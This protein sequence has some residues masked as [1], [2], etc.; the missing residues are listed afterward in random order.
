MQKFLY[1]IFKVIIILLALLFTACPSPTD[2][3]TM[4]NHAI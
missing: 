2:P 1:F 3:V 4:N